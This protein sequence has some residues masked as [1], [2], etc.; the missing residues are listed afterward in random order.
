MGSVNRLG[1]H[2]GL[3]QSD[4]RLIASG[5]F[6]DGLNA[7]AHSM[8]WFRDHLYVGTTRGN[9]PFMKARLPIGMNVW[10]VECPEDPYSL[11][12]GAEIWRY[13]PDDDTW[14]RVF[15]SPTIIGSHGKPIP[16]EL[17]LRGMLVYDGRAD[18]PP[19]L[20]V[21]TW[22]PARGP[23]PLLLRSEDGLNFAPTCEP[24]LVGLP[25]TTI[26][27][28]VQFKGRMFTTPAGSRGGNPNVSAHSVV[29]ESEDPANGKW[30]PVSDFG[31][32]D[33]GNKTIFE[34][35]AFG[36]H[37]YVGTFN[38]EGFQVWRSTMEGP[39]PYAFERMIVKGAYRG[40]LNQCVLSMYPFKGALY[41]GGGIQGGGVDTQ[42]RIGPAPPEMLRLHPDGRWDLL[43]GEP[44]DTPEGRKEPLSG[45]LPGF[46][47]FFNGYFWRMTAHDGWLYM[48][49]FEW[50]SVLG[51]ANRRRWPPAFEGIIG[52]IEPQNI[53]DNQSG[54]D[55][56]RS[57]D[58]DNWVPVTTQG[59]GNPYNMGLRNLVS[60]PRGLFLGTANPFG[61]KIMPLGGTRYVPNPRGGCE[62]YFAPRR[63]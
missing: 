56:Y 63:G 39:K 43:V 28:I 26:R 17:G 24:G 58:G 54:F 33:P 19:A 13:A 49:T 18:Q 1:I 12:M 42:N 21:S 4:F 34:M 53:L 41:I 40:P 37:L 47:N 61:P 27:T 10:P 50:S 11:D 57:F 15:K 60:T 23:G 3:G 16:R 36:D 35:A 8:A 44:R 48:G 20:F 9:F 6:G 52:H 45:Y 14:T 22:S 31:F 29:Y 5:G 62:V 51:Y 32:G 46:D 7:Y 2:P 59:M 38:L 30:E 25:V 55:L